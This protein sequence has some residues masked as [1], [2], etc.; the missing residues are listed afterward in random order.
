MLL[1]ESACGRIVAE[2]EGALPQ[3]P[4]SQPADVTQLLVAWSKG[5]RSAS[6]HLLPII[7]DELHRSAGS[8]EWVPA[9]RHAGE[10][11][12]DQAIEFLAVVPKSKPPSM[13]DHGGMPPRH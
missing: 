6:D 12:S 7:Y 13:G 1:T 5:D 4:A 10:N 8:T 9:Q 3:F 11:L 2:E